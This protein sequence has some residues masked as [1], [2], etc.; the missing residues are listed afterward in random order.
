LKD[1]IAK[2]LVNFLNN[3]SN[4]EELEFLLDWIEDSNNYQTFQKYISVHHFSNWAMNQSDQ[5]KIIN[6]IKN[7]IKSQKQKKRVS[8]FRYLKLTKYAA[9][10]LLSVGLG[11]YLNQPQI[12]L[13][14]IEEV[15]PTKVTLE[16]SE[17]E[18]I[19]I[20][21][22]SNE[23][24][25][26][27]GK[28][29]AKRKSK[30]ITYE[31]NLEVKEL[32]YNT[33]NVPYGKRFNVELSD[34]SVVYLN[35]GTS[36]KFP[37]QFMEGKDR[38]IEIEGEAFFDVAHDENSTFRVRSNGAI[39]EVYGTKFN[40]KNFPEDPFSEIILTEGSVG[41]KSDLNDK[42]MV[43]IKPSFKAKLN[44]S[45]NDVEVTQVNTKLYTSWIDGRVVFR[46][47]NIDNLIMK[48][49]RLYNV[50]ITN[51]NQKLSNN[52]FNATI[53]VENET[54]EDVLN[55]L[56]EVYSIDYQVVKNKII[57]K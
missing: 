41:V 46:N 4:I 39:L 29:T 30:T 18:Q 23:L 21:E 31:K 51:N 28:V 43:R 52:F 6:E 54:I 5:E 14:P 8:S 55:Y 7:K 35:S 13:K 33:L 37:V 11:Y 42:E 57:I 44:K 53:Y 50:S 1:S 45:G 16:T 9:I 12:E 32:K 48:L 26:I 10:V 36:I 27:E 24:I 15:V 25:E 22:S 17:G 19:I 49:E 3:Q 47:E 20:E 56:K 2:I 40:F 38:E 34:G